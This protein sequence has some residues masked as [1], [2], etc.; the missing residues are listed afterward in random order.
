M[1]IYPDLDLFDLFA[2][3]TIIYIIQNLLV[4]RHKYTESGSDGTY[5]QD[6]DTVFFFLRF[7]Y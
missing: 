3:N 7:H 6:P 1:P 4:F 2:K 5:V